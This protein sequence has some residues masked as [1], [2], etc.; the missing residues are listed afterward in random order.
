MKTISLASLGGGLEFY[1]FIVYGI[2][3][4][5]IGQTFFPSSDPAVS[6]VA[7]FAIFAVGYLSRPLGG[8]I[9]SHIGDRFGRRRAFMISLIVMTAAT[10]VMAAMPGYATIGASAAVLFAILRFIQGCC[11]GGELPGAITYVVETA[12][13]RAGLACGIMIFCVNTGAFLAN[14]VSSVLHGI[15]SPEAVQEYG[16]RIA[17]LVGGLLGIIGYRL[18]SSLHE[19]QVFRSLEAAKIARL[20]AV[21]VLRNHWIP[22]LIGVGIISINQALIATL[23]VAMAPYLSQVAGYDSRLAANAISYSI[24][25]LSLGIIVI[26]YLSDFMSRRH[27]YLAGTIGIAVGAYPF[28]VS[29]LAHSISLFGFLAMFAATCALVSGTFGAISA[30]LFPDRLRFSG[31]AISYNLSAAIVGG[32]TPLIVSIISEMTGN[33]AAP[34]IFLSSLAGLGIVSALCLRTAAVGRHGIAQ[35][36]VPQANS[37]LAARAVENA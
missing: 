18:R 9:L 27:L 20:P 33:R 30:E 13:K 1:D 15:L 21:D 22:V 26:G 19:T 4:K 28:Y 17:F 3:A 10:L 37:P 11:V 12:P 29:L 36:E 6:L 16:W 31:L 25:F 23:N 14:G 32:F 5:Y 35:G 8:I 24:G 7:A 2:F 34:G